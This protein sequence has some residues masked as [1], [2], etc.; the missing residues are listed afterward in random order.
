MTYQENELPALI[1]IDMVKDT[2]DDQKQYPIASLARPTI[3]PINYLIGKF[4]TRDW[5]VVFSTDAFHRQDFIFKGRLNPHSLAGTRGA[6]VIDELDRKDE[7]YW[8][9]KPRFSAFFNTGLET[10]LRQRNVTLCAVAGIATH[11]CVLATVLDA[12][13]HDFKA[14]LL[15]DCTASYSVAIHKRTLD[16]YRRNPLFPLLKVL[17]SKEFITEINLL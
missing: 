3:D 13:C 15:E 17:T 4:R 1:I 9:P 16:N 5:P 11:I 6:E 8:L 14:V 2:F 7:D 10:W 12:V